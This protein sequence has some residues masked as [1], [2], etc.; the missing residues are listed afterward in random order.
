MAEVVAGSM[1]GGTR[2]VPPGT[3]SRKR[4]QMPQRLLV[5]RM[6]HKPAMLTHRS[7]Q[8]SLDN[9]FVLIEGH[10]PPN[11]ISRA[12]VGGVEVAYSA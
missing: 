6:N 10:P 8:L 7:G 4:C 3:D 1:V 5:A 9:A 11:E 2:V 12:C